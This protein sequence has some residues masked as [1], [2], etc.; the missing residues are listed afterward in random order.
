MSKDIVLG[1]DLG[2]TLLKWG[3]V[4]T[5]G[6]IL[7]SGSE[8]LHDRSQDGATQLLK[9]VIVR[10][11]IKGE[12]E[13]PVIGIG[14]PG[15]VDNTHRI[16]RTAPN[17]PPWENYSLIGDLENLFPGHS[18]FLENDA[19]LLLYSERRWGKARGVDNF[20]ILTL[21]T[22]VG[23]AVMVN[24]EVLRGVGGG[25]GELGHIAID[26]EGPLC[27]CGVHGCLE[28]FCNIKGIMSTA[29]ELYKP[30]APP[31]SPEELTEA[32]VNGDHRALETWNRTGWALG[33]GIA[34]LVNIF[35]P[36][37]VLI[38]GGVSGAGDFILEPA[39]KVAAERS[40]R[41]N[42]NDVLIERAGLGEKAGLL[43]AAA[44]A[45]TKTGIDL[46]D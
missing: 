25:A 4:D 37:M 44:L 28:T 16:I 29:G 5:D 1:L 11:K 24:G 41:L 18:F 32:A 3:L 26:P 46:R 19:N 43:G 40:Y 27:G 15:L 9:K 31:G 7:L 14:A 38:G 13:I 36:A 30:D 6:K 2:G 42:W 12:Y 23:G 45:F 17:F 21:G 34:S 33:V 22:G 20:V 10:I 35:N 8:A 39:R